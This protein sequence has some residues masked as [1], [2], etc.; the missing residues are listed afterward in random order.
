MVPFSLLLFWPSLSPRHREVMLGHS[1]MYFVKFSDAL[2]ENADEPRITR[3][4]RMRQRKRIPQR[5]ATRAFVRKSCARACD[6]CA[7]C[8]L[9]TIPRMCVAVLLL[10]EGIFFSSSADS[11]VPPNQTMK[12]TAPLR[13]NFSVFATTPCR[14]LSLSR[15][16]A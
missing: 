15:W 6:A 13:S 2:R 1:L 10:L 12:P 8:N 9:L 14:G 7:I 3:M 11:P 4:P 5:I 16:A